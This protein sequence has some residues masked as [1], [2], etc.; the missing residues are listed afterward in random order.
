MFRDHR[1]ADRAIL[2]HDPHFEDMHETD[3]FTLIAIDVNPL[4]TPR[5][6]RRIGL[7]ERQVGNDF[8]E[9]ECDSIVTR[10]R[11]DRAPIPLEGGE[12][13]LLQ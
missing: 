6:I 8:Q 12:T 5:L 9:I 3:E 7:V 1:F 2:L 11:K 10:H 13:C 4:R